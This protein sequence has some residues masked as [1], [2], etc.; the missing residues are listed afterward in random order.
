MSPFKRAACV[1]LF[2]R[3]EGSSSLEVFL[4][5]RSP[6]LSF[7]G[8]FHVFP[9]GTVDPLDSLPPPDADHPDGD[10]L[11]AALRELFE[12]TGVLVAHGAHRL[13]PTTLFN[14]RRHLLDNPDAWHELLKDNGLTLDPA[15]LTPLGQWRTP[16]FS[17]LRFD[18]LYV[19]AEL[20]AEQSPS[21]VPGELVDGF[22]LS[23]EAALSGHRNGRY[24]ITYPVLETLKVL[25]EHDGDLTAASQTLEE[26]GPDAYPYAGGEILQGVHILPLASPTTPPLTHTNTYILGEREA[27]VV[28]PGTNTPEG[29]AAL[30]KYMKMLEEKGTRFTQIWL[31]HH[32]EDHVAGARELSERFGLPVFA[33]PATQQALGRRLPFGGPLRNGQ[34]HSLPLENGGEA[35]WRTIHTPGIT[36]GHVVFYEETR[37]HLLSGNLLLTAGDI[38]H[39]ATPHNLKDLRESL[40]KLLLL[41]LGIILPGHGATSA[42]GPTLIKKTL[43]HLKES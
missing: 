4:V 24:F 16:P 17:P 25:I 42:A 18:A 39:G 32:W 21:I 13:S 14:L 31:T 10:R 2:R 30:V 35:I 9:G 26:R 3:P 19:T 6:S 36:E 34:R 15:H 7:M 22:W 8:G 11:C 1:I 12:E 28:D 27:V 20:P 5:K 38:N 29:V 41:A 43:K 23:P 37:G 40:E 33:H